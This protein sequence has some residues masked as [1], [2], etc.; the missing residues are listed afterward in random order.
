MLANGKSVPLPTR[1]GQML[2]GVPYF[3]SQALPDARTI[4]LDRAPMRVILGGKPRT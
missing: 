1:T 4:V 3:D 2:V